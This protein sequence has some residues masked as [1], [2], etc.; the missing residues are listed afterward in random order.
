MIN[1]NDFLFIK[2]HYYKLLELSKFHAIKRNDIT[3][4]IYTLNGVNK[5][6]II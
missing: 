6:I 3:T 5:N 4:T 1:D 2:K